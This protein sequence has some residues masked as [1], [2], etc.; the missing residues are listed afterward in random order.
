MRYV[1]IRLYIGYKDKFNIDIYRDILEFENKNDFKFSEDQIE[2]LVGGIKNGVHIITGGPGTGKTTIIKF[3]LS[4]LL[5]YGFN[6]IMVAPTGRAAK[7]M[8]ET[9]GFEAKTIHRVLEISTSDN[10]EFGYIGKNENN[11]IKCDAIIIDEASMVDVLIASK[12][13]EALK[14]GTKIV[15]VGDVDQLPSIGPGNFLRDIINS[16]IFPVSYLNKIYRQ[17]QNSFI[18]LNAHKINNGE[19]LILNKKDSDFY[20]IKDSSE[21]NICKILVDLVSFRIPKFFEYKIDKL[22]DIQILS[23]IRGGVLGV[24]NLNSLLQEN[25][26]PKDINKD[27]LIYGGKCYR[28]GDKVMQ[29]KNNYEIRGYNIHDEEQAIGVFNGDI[30]YIID[31]N[32]KELS[33]IY[34]DSKVFKYTKNLLSEIEHAYAIT[35]H[36]SQGSEFPVIILPIFKFSSMLMNRNI[37]YTA[38]TRAKKYVVLV[39]DINYLTYMIKNTSK[40]IRYSSLKYLFNE[41]INLLDKN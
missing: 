27:E 18:V 5:N 32:E 9:T 2:A 26:N 3:I 11:K 25:I 17:K 38:V 23:P 8:M 20:I 35:I 4:T 14:I 6:P 37:L 34:D 39:G 12:L 22:K 28:V 30:G 16:G 15:I 24:L 29:I 10:E 13:F 19:E 33:I 7:R 31:I 41:V 21:E 36:K 1:L 40:I